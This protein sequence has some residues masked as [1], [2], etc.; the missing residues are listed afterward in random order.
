MTKRQGRQGKSGT[1][2]MKALLAGDEEFLRGLLRA[3]LQEMLEAEMTSIGPRKTA[4][5]SGKRNPNRMRR[6]YKY[7]TGAAAPRIQG[8]GG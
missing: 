8:L 5:R 6:T 7:R 1:I 3:A 4:G 2:D